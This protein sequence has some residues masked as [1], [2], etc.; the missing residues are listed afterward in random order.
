MVAYSYAEGTCHRAEHIIY[1]KS[2]RVATRRKDNAPVSTLGKRTKTT[3][4]VLEKWILV[5]GAGFEPAT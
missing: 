1:T 2:R 4:I 5:A 3:L